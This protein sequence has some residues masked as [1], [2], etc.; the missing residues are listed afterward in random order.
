MD[1]GNMYFKGKEI[2]K[3]HYQLNTFRLVEQIHRVNFFPKICDKV[4]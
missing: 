4:R 2:P 3:S 1:K